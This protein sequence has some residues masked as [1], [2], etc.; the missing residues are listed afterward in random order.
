LRV[1]ELARRLLA[2][3]GASV[4]GESAEESKKTLHRLDY[5]R[6]LAEAEQ[7]KIAAAGRAEKLKK[8]QDEQE[9]RRARRGKW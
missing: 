2:V 6:L 5:A 4:V 9:Q 3:L 8:L 7:A 1:E